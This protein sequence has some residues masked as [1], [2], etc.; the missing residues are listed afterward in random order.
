AIASEQATVWPLA[1]LGRVVWGMFQAV[2]TYKRPARVGLAFGSTAMADAVDDILMVMTPLLTETRNKN[3]DVTDT[4]SVWYKL[5][6]EGPLVLNWELAVDET[7]HL[8]PQNGVDRRP[9]LAKY[10]T[11]KF[12]IR[13]LYE[14]N[15][16]HVSNDQV[17]EMLEQAFVKRTWDLV[18]Q[19]DFVQH[20]STDAGVN[21]EAILS[22]AIN[23]ATADVFGLGQESYIL[24]RNGQVIQIGAVAGD[25]GWNNLQKVDPDLHARLKQLL[26]ENSEVRWSILTK[27]AAQKLKSTLQTQPALS[28]NPAVRDSPDTA[29]LLRDFFYK[30]STLTP[31]LD[32]QQGPDQLPFEPSLKELFF[33]SQSNMLNP[34]STLPGVD[35]PAPVKAVLLTALHDAALNGYF[36]G[37]SKTPLDTGVF[38]TRGNFNIE[39][40]EV[41]FSRLF[42][43]IEPEAFYN[44]AGVEFHE[45]LQGPDGT[46]VHRTIGDLRVLESNSS[47]DHTA[48]QRAKGQATAREVIRLTGSAEAAYEFLNKG[49]ANEKAVQLKYTKQFI[50]DA[51][52]EIYKGALERFL[53]ANPNPSPDV[54]DAMSKGLT[55]LTNYGGFEV[56]DSETGLPKPNL[57]TG[58]DDVLNILLRGLESDGFGTPGTKAFT[59]MNPV[60]NPDH[61]PLHQY[62]RNGL[63]SGFSKAVRSV[64][65]GDQARKLDL[66]L[67]TYIT[68]IAQD[69]TNT[70]ATARTTGTTSAIDPTEFFT[71][72]LQTALNQS[73]RDAAINEQFFAQ[74]KKFGVITTDL[75]LD[76]VPVWEFRTKLYAASQ[77]L[78]TDQA[79][80]VY[81][82]NA[83]LNNSI[84]KAK[85]LLTATPT[86]PANETRAPAVR[87]F[88]LA[89]LGGNTTELTPLQ[90][91][92]A[93]KV[94][95]LFNGREGFIRTAAWLV[96]GAENINDQAVDDLLRF[97]KL[98]QEHLAL[99]GKRVR[100]GNISLPPEIE[101]VYAPIGSSSNN[102]TPDA[103]NA[104]SDYADPADVL[105]QIA[106]DAVSIQEDPNYAAVARRATPAT[107]S[108]LKRVAGDLFRVALRDQ[109]TY[110]ADELNTAAK[111]MLQR[112]GITLPNGEADVQTVVTE[113]LAKTEEITRLRLSSSESQS[114]TERLGE[115]PQTPSGSSTRGSISEQPEYAPVFG[116]SLLDE[117]HGHQGISDPESPTGSNPANRIARGSAPLPATP[118]NVQLQSDVQLR[119]AVTRDQFS[120]SKPSPVPGNVKTTSVF[121]SRMNMVVEELIRLSLSTWIDD[122]FSTRAT[123][124]SEYLQKSGFPSTSDFVSQITQNIDLTLGDMFEI[125]LT[126]NEEGITSDQQRILKLTGDES[127][128]HGWTLRSGVEWDLVFGKVYEPGTGGEETPVRTIFQRKINAIAARLISKGGASAPTQRSAVETLTREFAA[129]LK[130]YGDVEVGWGDT[131][132]PPT[133][134]R[135]RLGQL[136]VEAAQVDNLVRSSSEMVLRQGIFESPDA[137]AGFPIPKSRSLGSGIAALGA[138][139]ADDAATVRTLHAA[140]NKAVKAPETSP[141]TPEQVQVQVVNQVDAI[142]GVVNKKGQS[143]WLNSESQEFKLTARQM[144]EAYKNSEGFLIQGQ[145]Y[146]GLREGIAMYLQEKFGTLQPLTQDLVDEYY[147]AIS[148]EL[149]DL[150]Q[151]VDAQVLP[152][153]LEPFNTTQLGGDLLDGML[154][155]GNALIGGNPKALSRTLIQELSR[156]KV[157]AVPATTAAGA[158]DPVYDFV[159]QFIAK[160][161]KLVVTNSMT[162]AEVLDHLSTYATD[163]STEQNGGAKFSALLDDL[164]SMLTNKGDTTPEGKLAIQKRILSGF[165]QLTTDLQSFNTSELGGATPEG[166]L[167]IGT[168]AANNRP[169]LLLNEIIGELSLILKSSVPPTTADGSA[170]PVYDFIFKF[171]YRADELTTPPSMTVTDLLDQLIVIADNLGT[172]QQGDKVNL[173]ELLNKLKLLVN[174][175]PDTT[176]EGKFQAQL[177][178]MEA[179]K[180]L[181]SEIRT[182]IPAKT[183]FPKQEQKTQQFVQ[184][185]EDLSQGLST[186]T[187]VQVGNDADAPPPLPS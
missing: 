101:D 139:G 26:I 67:N 176:Q 85:A 27:V 83:L 58:E 92:Q 153:S 61:D 108:L 105:R 146:E 131:A 68:D 4:S 164:K 158:A 110:T 174:G 150:L 117:L 144:A 161:Q 151:G 22:A 18:G 93:Q 106:A 169:Q 31:V 171:I 132:T 180:E 76:D 116:P 115:L 30:L 104:I 39:T 9:M 175:P 73:V 78:T 185:V 29:A 5:I 50:Q 48:E 12:F 141:Q 97:T 64:I 102:S 95:Q 17:V 140:V 60:L 112:Q 138:G 20:G 36:D 162:V 70:V 179:F 88:H 100:G 96:S 156:L 177:K 71:T 10:E 87:S 66:L 166:M 127:I 107:P 187:Q 55:R 184:L 7:R 53:R 145:G 120:K 103:A 40:P 11:V 134:D 8:P 72:R 118:D 186:A 113:F 82:R 178:A 143:L 19:S 33:R 16:I 172:Q 25:S 167:L 79:E 165:K 149:G 49:R 168:A 13:S 135:T 148:T 114:I 137:A 90:R 34:D 126:P 80:A 182:K 157:N 14:K 119:S 98:E 62:Y 44:T 38:S 123:H 47:P 152:S 65:F 57:A 2:V 32:P 181:T 41:M 89:I 45:F 154:S 124:V 94:L 23:E 136:P 15:G 170:V 63:A 129:N 163:L 21:F 77:G 159:G 142:Y 128:E 91:T 54:L 74:C 109:L 111:A 52:Q 3:I 122:S 43:L 59:R 35:L 86:Q 51:F 42:Q 147:K 37:A 173:T 133:G 46:T 24:E 121:S 130:Y 1:N 99:N 155:I 81:P 75:S 160:V 125:L 84:Q 28:Q 183:L 6:D 56:F 69:Y